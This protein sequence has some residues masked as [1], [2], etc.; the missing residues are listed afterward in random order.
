M[1]LQVA[2]ALKQAGVVFHANLNEMFETQ[3][4]SG[5]E[6]RFLEPVD[7]DVTYSFDGKAFS[8]TGTFQT[9]LASLCARCGEAFREPLN[10]SFEERFVK[11][12]QAEED[13][14]EVYLF[15]GDTLDL[16]SMVLDNL[17]LHLPIISVCSDDCK[18]LCPYC[19]CNL[20]ITQCAC[21]P[22]EPKP[23]NPLSALE[24]LLSDGKEV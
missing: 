7:L 12:A 16:T 3:A 4:F 5:R 24:Q 9:A 18:G 15:E 17:F 20:N 19:G 6:I 14:E 1:E 10:V 21:V 2:S 11:E 13:D 22:E 23:V 8:L